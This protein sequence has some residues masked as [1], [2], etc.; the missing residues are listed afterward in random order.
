MTASRLW[1]ELDKLSSLG[2]EGMID[3]IRLLHEGYRKDYGII[4]GVVH[5]TPDTVNQL[6]INLDEENPTRDG[7]R[8]ML[9]YTTWAE[10]NSD[11]ILSEPCEI[12]P[13][14]FV[15]DNA[16][17]KP[18]IGGLVFNRQHPDKCMNIPK[19]FLGDFKMVRKAFER[20]LEG[21]PNPFMF[22]EK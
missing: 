13:I 15:I 18:V 1:K 12:L 3:S 6:Y 14:R 21:N 7:N 2:A 5:I 19:Q 17:N 22:N 16:L 4:C 11:E 8:Y 20:A 10:A 9:C